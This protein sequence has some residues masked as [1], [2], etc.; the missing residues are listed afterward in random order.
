MIWCPTSDFFSKFGL[1]LLFSNDYLYIL[2]AIE[3]SL[4]R[5]ILS[6]RLLL[7]RN[8]F[9]IWNFKYNFIF[10][11]VLLYKIV[12]CSNLFEWAKKGCAYTFRL[13]W[14]GFIFINAKLWHLNIN[15][16]CLNANFQFLLTL[17]AFK[18]PKS[19]I[20]NANIDI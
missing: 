11:H 18:K 20:S 2:D 9:I 12:L 7:R 14:P 8:C 16:W 5:L 13:F 4:T 15:F 10:Y 3:T 1:I 17:L 6:E 19:G